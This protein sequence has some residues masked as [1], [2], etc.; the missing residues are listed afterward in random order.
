MLLPLL[1]FVTVSVT[2]TVVFVTVSV[3]ITI[4]FCH[5]MPGQG[6]RKQTGQAMVISTF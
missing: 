3:T 4:V 5:Y 2:A 1:Y 6:R